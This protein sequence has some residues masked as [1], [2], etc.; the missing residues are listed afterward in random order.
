MLLLTAQ[1]RGFCISG[2][3]SFALLNVFHFIPRR[4]HA[5][6]LNMQTVP[7]LNITYTEEKVRA[8]S[9]S[10]NA[11]RSFGVASMPLELSPQR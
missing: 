5:A 11:T 3:D 9:A 4:R 6:E 8:C 7:S 2:A 1:L 10:E